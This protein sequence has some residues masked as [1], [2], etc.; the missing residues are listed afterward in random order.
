MEDATET[1]AG[2][3]DE[4][5]PAPAINVKFLNFTETWRLVEE[6]RPAFSTIFA[7]VYRC[8]ANKVIVLFKKPINV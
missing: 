7:I 4:E 8:E 1:K 3:S 6:V 2:E 5:M